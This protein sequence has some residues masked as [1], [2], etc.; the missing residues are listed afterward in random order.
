MT[1][2]AELEAQL[3]AAMTTEADFLRAKSDLRL[4]NLMQNGRGALDDCVVF[5]GD[6]G[7]TVSIYAN[8]NDDAKTVSA[9]FELGRPTT[10]DAFDGWQWAARLMHGDFA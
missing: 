9:S 10:E 8:W 2:L 4:A 3:Q 7:T 6:D 5:L 1:A